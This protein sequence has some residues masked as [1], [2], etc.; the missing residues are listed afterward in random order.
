M[1]FHICSEMH[2]P[3]RDP[4]MPGIVDYVQFFFIHG[5]QEIVELF[6]KN[7]C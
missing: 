5:S 2:V 7:F 3:I 1:Y 4:T 6:F